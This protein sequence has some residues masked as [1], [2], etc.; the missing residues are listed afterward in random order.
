MKSYLNAVLMVTAIYA[1][2]SY[3]EETVERDIITMGCHKENGNCFMEINGEPVGPSECIANSVRFNILSDKN[4]EASF[5]L[6]SAA[7]FSGKKVRF[8]ISDQCYS[9]QNTFPTFTRFQVLN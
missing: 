8:T 2:T 1:G 3:A 6:L 5:T 7:F 4:A 9:Q